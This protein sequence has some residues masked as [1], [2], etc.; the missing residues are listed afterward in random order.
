MKQDIRIA[1]LRNRH[2]L[3]EARARLLASL[4]FGG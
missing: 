4:A 2:G 1:W 3:S